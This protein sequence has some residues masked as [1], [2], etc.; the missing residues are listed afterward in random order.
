MALV[1]DKHHGDEAGKYAEWAKSQMDYLLGENPLNRCYIVGYNE[2][3]AKNPHH[4][5]SSGFSK[6]EDEGEQRYVLYGAL[7]G[8]PDGDDNHID[9]T[10]DYIYNEVTIDYNA[11]FVGACAGQYHFFGDSSMKVTPDFPPAPKMEGEDPE[12]PSTLTPTSKYWVE[13][14]CVD[15]EQSD[16]PKATEVTFY[17]CSNTT[18]PS[19]NLSVRYYFDST[20][21]SSLHEN[22]MTLR[23]L[24]DQ[25]YVEADHPGTL[26]GPTQYKDNIYYVEVSWEDYVIA[27]SNKKFQF[28]LGTY[29]WGNSW[30][31]SDDWSHQDLR[32]EQ[33]A[34]K[35]TVEKTEYI[36][37]Y[38]NGVLVGGTEPDGTTPDFGAAVPPVTTKPVVTTPPS[39][40]KPEITTTP[41]E[42]SPNSPPASGGD[43][44]DIVLG[45][46]DMSG[47]VDL[48]DLSM[49]SMH[50]IGDTELTGAAYDAAD[51]DKNGKL[52]LSDLAR[53]RQY[54]SK[55][56]TS[57]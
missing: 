25:A 56:I 46:V 3:S 48:T 11:A 55:R 41:K 36:C 21:M 57:F 19:K 51:V 29:A 23:T 43:V 30:N 52:N 50:L 2:T 39:T 15:I 7:V 54:I 16:G 9:I 13:A 45:D 38:D 31:P 18:K 26:T 14:F 1:Y 5:A 33:D 27:N 37:V 28:A 44:D 53:I 47:V 17:V 8:G 40:T 4:R 42:D 32:Q 49:V 35:G 10:A 24:Y 20:G 12:D 34:F 22:E 6:C